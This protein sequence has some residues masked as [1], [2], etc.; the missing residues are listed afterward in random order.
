MPTM[1]DGRGADS[2][3]DWFGTGPDRGIA[4][5]FT[6]AGLLGIV[7]TTIVWRSQAYRRLAAAT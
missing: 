5:M 6:V 3:G 2:I 7:V 4:L 1:T